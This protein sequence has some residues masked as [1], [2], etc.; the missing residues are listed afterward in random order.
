M[1][2]EQVF[3][4]KRLDGGYSLVFEIFPQRQSVQSV[5]RLPARQVGCREL[6]VIGVQQGLYIRVVRESAIALFRG[7]YIKTLLE[8]R[9]LCVKTLFQK[10]QSIKCRKKSKNTARITGKAPQI[11]K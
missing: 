10:C 1:A 11:L 4:P 6:P 8:K 7:K 2:G 3:E 5:E 9:I